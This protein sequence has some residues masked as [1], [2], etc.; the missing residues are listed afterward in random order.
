MSTAIEA[1]GPLGDAWAT[2]GIALLSAARGAVPVA[3]ARLPRAVIGEEGTKGEHVHRIRKQI[4]RGRAR[5]FASRGPRSRRPS[6]KPGRARAPRD[7]QGARR[8]AGRA[9]RGKDGLHRL[10]RRA[11]AGGRARALEHAALHLPATAAV[12]WPEISAAL[13]RALA[14]AADVRPPMK[15]ARVRRGVAQVARRARARLAEVRHDPLA[16]KFHALRRRVKDLLF[17]MEL[18]VD[19][20]RARHRRVHA[21]LDRLASILGKE[22]DLT[23]ALAALGR[24]ATPVEFAAAADWLIARRAAPRTRAVR[25]ARRLLDPERH[26]VSRITRWRQGA[27]ARS[28]RLRCRATGRA[29]VERIVLYPAA[30]A[31]EPF[32]TI[33]SP[34]RRRLAPRRAAAGRSRACGRVG[35]R[36]TRARRRSARTSRTR[37]AAGG[38]S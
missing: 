2:A 17:Q 6:T 26:L 38:S 34:R 27:A 23:L 21:R 24:A 30:E 29:P 12:A 32:F 3:T 33:G 9:R 15:R 18:L 14:G 4:K 7:R 31:V 1:D 8:G 22:H 16:A 5:T 10:T 11:P 36:P 25:R 37:R 35:P 28:P 20:R 19:L 13:E